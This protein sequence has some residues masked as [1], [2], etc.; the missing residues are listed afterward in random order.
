MAIS[1]SFSWFVVT[2]P[3][4]KPFMVNDIYLALLVIISILVYKLTIK[5]DKKWTLSAM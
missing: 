1:S 5:K 2:T 4:V 3:L